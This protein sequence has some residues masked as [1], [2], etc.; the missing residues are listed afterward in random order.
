M[1]AEAEAGK[2]V[3]HSRW[4]RVFSMRLSDMA[5]TY[6]SGDGVGDKHHC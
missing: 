5:E 6:G 4:Y 1:E 2:F 3:G